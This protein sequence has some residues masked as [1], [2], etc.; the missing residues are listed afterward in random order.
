MDTFENNVHF[1][2]RRISSGLLGQNLF[3]EKEI[4][5]FFG[6][7][8]LSIYIMNHPDAIVCSLWKILLF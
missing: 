7:C 8:D 3:S 1:D 6:T 4:Q 2:E 5:C